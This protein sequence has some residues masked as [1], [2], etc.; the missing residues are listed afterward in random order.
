MEFNVIDNNG[1]FFSSYNFFPKLFLGLNFT[2]LVCEEVLSVP[3][4]D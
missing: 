3:Y 2:K 1:R 4:F